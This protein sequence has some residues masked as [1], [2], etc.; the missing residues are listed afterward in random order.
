MSE[1]QHSTSIA[2]GCL[3]L[4]GTIAQ[5]LVAAKHN[6]EEC[7]SLEGAVASIGSFLKALPE[8]GVTP[9]GNKVLGKDIVLISESSILPSAK[10]A[11]Y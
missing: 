11:V 8:D 1:D 9:A 5:L 4:C 7:R 3:T 2:S 10:P 6:K